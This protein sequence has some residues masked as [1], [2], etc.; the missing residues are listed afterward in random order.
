[1]HILTDD[2]FIALLV[3]SPCL[4]LVAGFAAGQCFFREALAHA[5]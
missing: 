2:Q 4:I 5:E 3:A 1:M